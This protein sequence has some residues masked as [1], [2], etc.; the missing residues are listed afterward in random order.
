MVATIRNGAALRKVRIGAVSSLRHVVDEMAG[1]AVHGCTREWSQDLIRGAGCLDV[2]D[3][4]IALRQW[5]VHIPL[6]VRGKKLRETCF[7]E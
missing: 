3:G 2:S 5:L 7:E 6:I 1:A 4:G